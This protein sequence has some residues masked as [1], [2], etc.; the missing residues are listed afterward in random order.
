MIWHK[1]ATINWAN[2][3]EVPKGPTGTDMRLIDAA[4][5]AQGPHLTGRTSR[6]R[7]YFTE[8]FKIL[9]NIRFFFYF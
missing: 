5:P 1:N 9:C 3:V 8:A 2:T 6:K 4:G 7:R